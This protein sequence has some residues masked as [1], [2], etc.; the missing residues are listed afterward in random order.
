MKFFTNGNGKVTA[1]IDA[2]ISSSSYQQT[3]KG[4]QSRLRNVFVE[5]KP[6][7]SSMSNQIVPDPRVLHMAQ[8]KQEKLKYDLSTFKNRNRFSDGFST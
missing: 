3:F 1:Y 4:M 7:M 2:G 8:N 6:L 5:N